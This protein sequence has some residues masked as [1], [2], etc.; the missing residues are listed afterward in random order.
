LK[1]QAVVTRVADDPMKTFHKQF[2]ILLLLFLVTFGPTAYFAFW[3]VDASVNDLTKQSA[4]VLVWHFNNVVTNAV[5]GTG[6][7]DGLSKSQHFGLRQALVAELRK[8]ENIKNVLLVDGNGNIAF[9]LYPVLAGTKYLFELETEKPGNDRAIKFKLHGKNAAGAFDAVWPVSTASGLHA[10]LEIDSTSGQVGSILQ[11]FRNQFTVIAAA[12]FVAVLFLAFVGTGIIKSPLRQ[13]DKAMTV[14]ENA[15][16]GFRL[17]WRKNA[18]FADLYKKVNRALG[19]VETSD[20]LHRSLTQ[21]KKALQQQLERHERFLRILSHEIRNPLHALT[22]NMDV[23]RTKIKKGQSKDTTL[24][25]SDIVDQELNHLQEIVEGFLAYVR[26]GAPKKEKIDLN[27]VIKEVCHALAAEAEKAQ[28]QIDTRLSRG[29][30]DVMIDKNQFQQTLHN[31]TLNAIQAT[32]S[33]GR[34]SIRTTQKRKNVAVTIKDTGAGIAKDELA[35][36]FDLYYTTKK[37]GSGIGIPIS[38]RM[39]EANGGNMQIE[40]AVGKGTTVT[41]TFPAA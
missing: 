24:K 31:L 3:A 37:G 33:S 26:P 22:I 4:D 6:T 40:S 20:E 13:I 10:V 21:S 7:T 8:L 15:E 36:V 41:I 32:P 11:V 29:L 38:Q 16:S 1:L 9:S 28:I 12:G 27:E 35:K 17:R 30:R 5:S 2:I 25:Y 39:I 18:E 23:L 19:K 14:V 34:I